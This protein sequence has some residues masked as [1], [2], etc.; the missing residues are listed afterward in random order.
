VTRPGYRIDRRSGLTA[1]EREVLDLLGQGMSQVEV[2]EAI[3]VSKQRVGQ[4][5]LVLV[6]KGRWQPRQD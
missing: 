6:E 4:I 5:L 3:G 2:A 1:R